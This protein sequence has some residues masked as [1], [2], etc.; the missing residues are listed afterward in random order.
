MRC[1]L[2][3]HCDLPQVWSDA[4]A[5]DLHLPWSAYC[6]L[7]CSHRPCSDTDWL[8]PRW[9][10]SRPRDVHFFFKHTF[11]GCPSHS[12]SCFIIHNMIHHDSPLALAKC[13]TAL[14]IL[15]SLAAASTA[16]SK[17]ALNVEP[18]L[19]AQRSS[20]SSGSSKTLGDIAGE[21]CPYCASHCAS[22]CASHHFPAVP[23]GRLWLRAAESGCCEKKK[24]MKAVVGIGKRRKDAQSESTSHLGSEFCTSCGYDH[25]W[26]MD[27]F[28]WTHIWIL[29]GPTYRYVHSIAL[30]PQMPAESRQ[31]EA[32]SSH[33]EINH[34]HEC[35]HQPLIT[36]MNV[37]FC[38]HI[39]MKG[40][41]HINQNILNQVMNLLAHVYK[42]DQDITPS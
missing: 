35:N 21:R 26:I 28:I 41:K 33:L 10:A 15:V 9:E 39:Y 20:R 6:W 24:A 14:L 7:G 23:R 1:A 12:Q 22:R 42:H 17:W 19:G 29:G 36:N 8:R 32:F 31:C 37:R 30:P 3:W 16:I 13:L 2:H 25:G 40:H 38:G 5:C 34:R 4:T 18:M 11:Q 27:G